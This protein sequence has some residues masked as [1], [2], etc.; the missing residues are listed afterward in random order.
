V[1]P[2]CLAIASVPYRHFGDMMGWTM[3]W[4]RDRWLTAEDD[5]WSLS[6]LP[7]QAGWVSP[8]LPARMDSTAMGLQRQAPSRSL[9]PT[10]GCRVGART[11]PTDRY[12]DS[13]QGRQP[14][15][16]GSDPVRAPAR[17]LTVTALKTVD[18]QTS[19]ESSLPD[20]GASSWQYG[21]V[22]GHGE[23][24]GGCAAV[25]RLSACHMEVAFGPWSAGA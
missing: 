14:L 12:Q 6:S 9:R 16:A 5:R 19:V 23:P 1:R 8:H 22:V 17:T 7:L 11:R 3:V 15:V 13:P 20:D 25:S 24:A 21:T 10:G 18:H 2:D 4:L